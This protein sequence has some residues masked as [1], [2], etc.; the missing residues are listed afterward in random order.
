M[1]DGD[2]K[3]IS[4]P[5]GGYNAC[6]YEERKSHLGS[7]FQFLGFGTTNPRIGSSDLYAV[8]NVKGVIKMSL[9]SPSRY[10]K[11]WRV[12]R[13]CRVELVQSLGIYVMSINVIQ[14]D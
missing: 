14:S 6:S 7:L 10:I 1:E 13:V 2:T 5:F 3:E 4:W 8:V 12:D 9:R 11:Y